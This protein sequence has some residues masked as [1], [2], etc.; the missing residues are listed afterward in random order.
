MQITVSPLQSRA[1]AARALRLGVTV[2]EIMRPWLIDQASDEINRAE[3]TEEAVQA[4]EARAAAAVQAREAAQI[5]AEAAAN[6]AHAA[7]VE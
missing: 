5:S 3:L 7:T 2:E 4:A 1:I 6:G